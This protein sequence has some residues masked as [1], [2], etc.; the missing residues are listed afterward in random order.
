MRSSTVDQRGEVIVRRKGGGG[1]KE[2][3][4]GEVRRGSA[5]GKC[6]WEV[7][8]GSAKGKCEEGKEEDQDQSHH[9]EAELPKGAFEYA[10]EMHMSGIRF[11]SSRQ[12]IQHTVSSNS[13][14]YLYTV[15]LC[16]TVFHQHFG[17]FSTFSAQKAMPR[18]SKSRRK[19][20]YR[21]CKRCRFDRAKVTPQ[22]ISY[23][24]DRS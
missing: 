16:Q 23:Y 3:Y 17:V 19:L 24:V 11:A 12:T 13:R 18:A 20:A 1:A 14:E 15:F 6:E 22:F 4:E 2:K 8:R 7:R 21:K 5:K 10:A 9:R